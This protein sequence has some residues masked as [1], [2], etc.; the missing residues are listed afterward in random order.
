VR[1]S[2]VA[3]ASLGLAVAGSQLAHAQAYRLA[4]PD[5]ARRGHLLEETG[6]AY[7]HYL[8]LV[9]ALVTT[10]VAMAFVS[11][12]RRARTGG[13]PSR[14]RLWGFALVAPALF[15]CQEHFERLLHDGT[16][17]WDATSERTFLLGLA[18][19][20][21]FA[22]AAYVLARLLLRAAQAV[23]RLLSARPPVR[24]P[25]RGRVLA[26][27]PIP[28]CARAT[29]IALGPRGPPLLSP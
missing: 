7:L 29:G 26:L 10:V 5:P 23:G 25:D 6:H 14:P 3:L 12:A 24:L 18:L 19:Q 28:P 27:D 16:F 4:V 1:R 17:P 15:C 8:P 13:P 9:L 2:I 22:L 21:P 20:L 11:E